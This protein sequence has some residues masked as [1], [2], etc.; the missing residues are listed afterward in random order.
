MVKKSQCIENEYFITFF[1]IFFCENLTSPKSGFIEFN[2]HFKEFKN[3]KETLQI[4]D[5]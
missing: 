5:F 1:I 3:E 4:I 2:Q